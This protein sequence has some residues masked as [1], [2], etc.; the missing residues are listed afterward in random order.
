MA[1]ITLSITGLGGGNLSKS[2]TISG[3]HANTADLVQASLGAAQAYLALNALIAAYFL[4]GTGKN[5][6]KIVLYGVVML[7]VSLAI[8]SLL[9]G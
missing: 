3:T 9:A 8:Y 4:G 1:Q 7:P 6:G 5:K 2:V